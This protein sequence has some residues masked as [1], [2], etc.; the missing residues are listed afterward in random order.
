[1]TV[2][3]RN[4]L[5]ALATPPLPPD[6]WAEEHIRIPVRGNPEPGRY[7]L[8]R[9]PYWREP[10]Q[11][12]AQDDPHDYVVIMKTPQTGA[13]QWSRVAIGYWIDT[14][15]DPV[16]L[17]YPNQDACEEQIEEKV[18]PTI[19]ESPRLARWITGR[20][21][22][23]TIDTV[24]LKHMTIYS[25]WAS[26]PQMLASRSVPRIVL[27]ETDKNQGSAKEADPEDLAKHRSNADKGRRKILA[28]STPTTK[29]G[30]VSR[31]FRESRDKRH[32]HCGCHHCGDLV[33]WEWK[34]FRWDHQA[35]TDETDGD[36]AIELIDKLE[37]EEARAWVVCPSCSAEIHEEQRLESV[38]AGNY[39]SEGYPPGERPR[40][41]RV[42]YHVPSWLSPWVTFADVVCAY[43]KSRHS[44]DARDF[45]NGFLALPS[46]EVSGTVDGDI[47]TERNEA[48]P[49]EIPKW[50]TAVVAGA[51]TQARDGKPFW[52]YV[53]RAFGKDNRSQLVTYGKAET[54]A[55][56]LTSTV[57][58]SFLREGLNA[59][60]SDILMVDSGGGVETD[61]GST[62]Y[63]VYEGARRSNGLAVA[64]RGANRPQDR[65][66]KTS[67]VDY[68]VPNKAEKGSA[69][70][71]TLDTERLKDILVSLIRSA[72]PIL[73]EENQLVTPEY[74][75]QMTSEEKVRVRIG[76]KWQRRWMRTSKARN[77][78]WDATVYALAGAIL[79]RAQDRETASAKRKASRDTPAT[80]TRKRD[81]QN[82]QR[83]GGRKRR[84]GR[85]WINK[86]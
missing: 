14:T 39:E 10:L 5:L 84:D 67:N 19:K 11:A 7:S 31:M 36:A 12:I 32:W 48:R 56:L 64:I 15:A 85:S 24:T 77:D 44:D 45:N 58:A 55:D 26:S 13:S 68:P 81:T 80:Q 25:G 43:L 57:H 66:I 49:L 28:I 23:I 33:R 2:A 76:R 3:E 34:H 78:I 73:W 27:D 86:R 20:D 50:A 51:D 63:L 47:F 70:V 62:T 9:T 29:V 38:L 40:S 1:M 61:D 4:T 83:I 21:R 54:W 59:I 52:V 30:T 35:E 60:G 17:I 82:R 69:Y 6:E 22:D 79:M 18:V 8:D 16:L 74:V 71:L 72:E 46:E 53:V 75:A 41:K 65:L 42:A 37:T